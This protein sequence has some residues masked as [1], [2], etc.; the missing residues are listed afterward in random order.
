MW[1]VLQSGQADLNNAHGIDRDKG[2]RSVCPLKSTVG[3]TFG[4]VVTAAVRRAQP[5]LT[6]LVL[7]LCPS[8][9]LSPRFPS[10]NPS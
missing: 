8:S 2:E 1:A 6:F 7:P 3:K 10:P 9:L 4:V 5:P